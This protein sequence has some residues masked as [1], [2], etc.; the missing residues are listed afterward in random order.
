MQTQMLNVVDLHPAAYNPRK[1]SD[2]EMRKLMRSI[3]GF[4]FV[5]PVVVNKD[6]TI[7]GGHQRVEAAKNLGMEQVPCVLVDLPKNKEKALNLALNRIGGEWDE[8]MLKVL[9]TE[10]DEAERMMSGFDEAETAKL[11]GEAINGK[12]DDFDTTPP[13]EPKTKLGDM[14]RMGYHVL[15][16]GDATKW[17]DMERLMG[18]E[19]ADMVFTDPPYGVDYSGGIQF[20]DAGVVKEQRERLEN[21]TSAAIYTDSVPMMAMFCDGPIYTWF[22]GTKGFELYQS[23]ESIGGQIHAMIVWIKNGGYGAL[24]ASYKQRHEPCLFWKPSGSSLKFCGDSNENTVWEISKDGK[25][26]FHPTQ[27]PVALAARAIQNHNAKV[28]L[29]LFGG[30]GSTLVACEQAGRKCR[31]MELDGRYCDVIIA[32]WEKLTGKKAEK[33]G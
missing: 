23:I 31:M 32:R 8:A 28:V 12:E 14:Y 19:K 20:T 21:D 24:N 3:E 7:I 30:S 33:V 25:N 2:W 17:E 5:E 16:C 15:L 18:G 1:I 26:E 29:D 10:L 27:K 6:M 9:L 22:A 13:E 4:G 11:L